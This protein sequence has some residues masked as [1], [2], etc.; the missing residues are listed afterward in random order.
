MYSIALA[1]EFRAVVA[2]FKRFALIAA[3]L[4]ALNILLGA[5]QFFV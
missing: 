4:K 5:A 3:E 2:L 1:H